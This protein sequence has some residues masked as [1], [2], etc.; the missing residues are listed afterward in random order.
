MMK[1]RLPTGK[2]PTKDQFNRLMLEQF[3]PNAPIRLRKDTRLGN[4]DL[5]LSEFRRAIITAYLEQTDNSLEW[6]KYQL[7]KLNV[8]WI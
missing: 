6:C 7:S 1:L 5:T 2:L 4:V 8:E 3:P